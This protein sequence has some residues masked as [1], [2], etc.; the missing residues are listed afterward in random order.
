MLQCTQCSQGQ[1]FPNFC[2]LHYTCEIIGIH[3]GIYNFPFNPL[4]IYH[5]LSLSQ[6]IYEYLEIYIYL[7]AVSSHLTSLI[8]SVTL[9]EM[10]YDQINF[11]TE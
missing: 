8:G 5:S 7:Y 11:T 4:H 3:V 1:Y 9:R 2:S 6:S 10:T